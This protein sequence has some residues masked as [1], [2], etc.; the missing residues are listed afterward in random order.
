MYSN[1]KFFIYLIIPE[2]KVRIWGFFGINPPLVIILYH[3]TVFLTL[4]DYFC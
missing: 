3:T 1:H 2:I 4:L